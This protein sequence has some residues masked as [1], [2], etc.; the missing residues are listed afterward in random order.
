VQRNKANNPEAHGQARK[1]DGGPQQAPDDQ[2]HGHDRDGNACRNLQASAVFVPAPLLED[3]AQ[4][5]AEPAQQAEAARSLHQ[6]Q[7]EKRTRQSRPDQCV[8][9]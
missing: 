7:Q 5:V 9:A 1:G 4:E 3:A 8:G 6:G 2:G